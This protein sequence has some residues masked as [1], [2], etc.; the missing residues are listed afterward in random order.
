MNSGISGTITA[1]QR[2][3]SRD[4]LATYQLGREILPQQ[5]GVSMSAKDD[6][7][8]LAECPPL[9]AAPR[10]S[11]ATDQRNAPAECS[12]SLTTLADRGLADFRTSAATGELPISLEN[13]EPMN[14]RP[15]ASTFLVFMS[16]LFNI[17]NNKS[18]QNDCFLHASCPNA[19][20]DKRLQEPENDDR[21]VH[22]ERRH[23]PLYS[24]KQT[25]AADSKRQPVQPATGAVS[26]H[27]ALATAAEVQAAIAGTNRAF[28]RGPTHTHRSVAPAH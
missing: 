18:N 12:G 6:R 2:H 26:R 27:V 4:A 8:A 9:S 28:S 7:V 11:S 21:T 22:R 23:L 15:R 3:R 25:A 17:L 20:S 19:V 1:V 16:S 13:A 10:S 5:A 24:G 14:M